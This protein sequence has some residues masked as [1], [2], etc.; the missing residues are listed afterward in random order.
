V[1]LLL[2]RALKAPQI[3]ISASFM[4]RY[5]FNPLVLV[6]IFT[7][8]ISC[9]GFLLLPN[10]LAAKV[11]NAIELRSG[12]SLEVTGKSW[13]V[14]SPRLGLALHDV[15]LA[16][17]SA[18]AEPVTHAREIIVPLSLAQAL[19]GRVTVEHLGISGADIEVVIN[20]QGHANVMIE[21]PP[22]STKT[23]SNSAAQP[24]I[25]FNISDSQFHFSDL[26]NGDEF[27]I[28]NL[29]AVAELGEGLTVEGLGIVKDNASIF[30][31]C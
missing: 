27:E 11:K 13:F 20:G 4:K 30:Q 23:D 21:Q 5:L 26:R 15:N 17:A 1:I 29:S 3:R 7:F 12:R 16:G 10:F 2:I 14:F 9:T 22:D 25:H 31:R 18:M 6:L 24:N 19:S 8:V 28:Q